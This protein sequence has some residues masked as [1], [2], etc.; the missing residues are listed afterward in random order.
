VTPDG[1]LRIVNKVVNP[2]LF[3]AIRG[4]GGGTFGVIVQATW[5]V[6]PTVPMT[7]FNWYMNSTLETADLEPGHLPTTK[8]MEYLLG[9]L[10]DLKEKGITLYVYAYPTV[11]RG[12]AIHPAANAGVD[13]ANAV[14]GP[15]LEKM[16]SFPGMTPF[17]TRP[18][19]LQT[20]GSSSTL[21]TDRL[22]R[23]QRHHKTVGT[24]AWC[25][26]IADS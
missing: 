3:W 2:D 6:Y 12:Y 21:P 10:P 5:K 23:S 26:T 13:K 4:G 14:W 16:Q 15:I 1:E 8:A 19:D 22:R 18:F 24:A 7:G 11:L 9:Q 17:Q 20:T 25:R